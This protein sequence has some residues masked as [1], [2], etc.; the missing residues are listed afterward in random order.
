MIS[1]SGHYQLVEWELRS[2]GVDSEPPGSCANSRHSNVTT[3]RQVT[4]E[5][6][7][8][9]QWLLSTT[10]WLVHDFQVWRIKSTQY[11]T[12]QWQHFNNYLLTSTRVA[13]VRR[14]SVSMCVC[15]SVCPQD[16]TKTAETIITK[17]AKGIVHQLILGQ[18][19]KGQ[20]H[21]VTNCKK[22]VRQ[23]SGR[24]KYVLYRVGSV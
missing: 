12:T 11:N 4:E 19:V 6:P 5:Q 18:K 2:V 17:L 3:D 7:S 8:I 24:R 20:G 21:R 10:W 23:S 13:R 14:S 22:Y 1:V 9:D 15:V 16:R